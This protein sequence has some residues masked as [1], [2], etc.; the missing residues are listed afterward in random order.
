MAEL[1]AIMAR[2]LAPDG[3]PWDREQT[4][5][6]LRPYLLEE[7]YEV[8][9]A[10]E[11][12]DVEEHREELGD[13]LL[14][15]VFQAALRERAGAFDI[16]DVVAA[17]NGKLIRRHPHVFADSDAHTP[18]EV[19]AQWDR[20]KA[21]EKAKKGAEKARTLAGLPRAL[22]A[23]LRAQKMGMRASR[24]GFDWPD[25]SGVWAKLREELAELEQAVASESEDRVA[26]ELGDL[27]F[28]TVNLARKLG[29]DAEGALRAA[30]QRFF[31]RFAHV[32]DELAAAGRSPRESTLEE[33][34]ALWQKAKDHTEDQTAP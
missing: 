19:H 8:L 33:M 25:T 27:L 5:E 3:C 10:M 1:C 30:N 32:E 4:L 26:A 11:R 17:I 7:T 20:I 9:D 24:V 18:A 21:E 14:Q 23:L 15:V 6:T 31:D 34:D 29:V 13:L 12:D 28:A 2:L 22:P 16:D